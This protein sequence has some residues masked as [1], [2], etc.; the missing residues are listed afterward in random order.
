MA[1]VVASPGAAA[2]AEGVELELAVH[3][4]ARPVRFDRL[5]SSAQ[6]AEGA[7]SDAVAAS[8]AASALLWE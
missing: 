5:H 3:H 6:Q 2:L 4:L 7:E 1:W 8:G